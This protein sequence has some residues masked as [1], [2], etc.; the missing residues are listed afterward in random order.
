MKK[1]TFK[2]FEHS[3]SID[4]IKDAF[5]FASRMHKLAGAAPRGG[6]SALWFRGESILGR[7]L[8]PGIGRKCNQPGRIKHCDPDYRNKVLDLEKVLLQRFRRDGFPFVQRVLSDW[9]AITLAQHHGLSTRLLDWSSNP[10]VALFFSAEAH[11]D[12]DGVIYAY[13]QRRNWDHHISMFEGQNPQRPRVPKPL[14]QDGIKIVYPM[15]LADRLI[16]QSGGFTIQ[17]PL[18]CLKD[19][20]EERFAESELDILEL[21]Q[22]ILP[23]EFKMKILDQLHRCSVNRRTLFPGLDGLAYTLVAQERFRKVAGGFSGRY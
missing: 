12:D 17:H 8:L 13:R 9:E 7:K 6:T 1:V 21:H 2:F 11:L 19:R 18:R 4:E 23:C 10:L 15:L 20:R 14:H 3:E 22:W 5:E 16:A